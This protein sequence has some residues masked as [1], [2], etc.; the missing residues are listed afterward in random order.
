MTPT[1]A[2]PAETL[3]PLDPLS[4][5]E[6][7]RAWEILAAERSPGPK[8]RAIFI[9]LHEPDKK[10]VLGHQPGD[11]VERAAFAVLV[12]GATGKTYEAVVSLS[13]G[14]VLSSE[15]VPGAEPAIVLAEVIE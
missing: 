12:D 7:E 15:H 5:A 1:T 8:S 13:Q 14:R 11:A 9:M 2:A 6:I 4:A 10:V 3:H